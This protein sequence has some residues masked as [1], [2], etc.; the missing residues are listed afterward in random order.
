MAGDNDE[1]RNRH[2]RR[3][4]AEERRLWNYV[5]RNDLPLHVRQQEEDLPAPVERQKPAVIPSAS[6]RPKIPPLRA[7]ND[8]PLISDDYTN[9][10]GSNADRLRRG[11]YPIDATLDLHFHTREEAHG[12]LRAFIQAQYMRGSRCM[13]I[14]TGKGKTGDGV[15]RAELPR[16]LNEPDLRAVV[17][18]FGHAKPPHGGSGAFYVLL[19]R[20]R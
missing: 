11:N 13:L 19:K 6:Q 20:K 3:L 10:D 16:W 8:K 7:R 17:L 4:T 18:A 2:L 5:T 14:I 9:V 1:S 15:L 12:M